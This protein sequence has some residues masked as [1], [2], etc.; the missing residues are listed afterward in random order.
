MVSSLPINFQQQFIIN[1]EV[2]SNNY[3]AIS[4]LAN[5]N[6]ETDVL[7]NDDCS[8]MG[9]KF[10]EDGPPSLDKVRISILFLD[11]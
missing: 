11:S 10:G 9:A 6:V 1:K 4:I 5:T 2:N 3:A 7:N 8:Y